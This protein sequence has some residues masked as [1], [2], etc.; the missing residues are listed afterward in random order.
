MESPAAAAWSCTAELARSK[1]AGAPEP[2]LLT[3]SSCRQSKAPVRCA[4]SVASRK[5]TS[6]RAPVRWKTAPSSRGAFLRLEGVGV[7]V[8]VVLGLNVGGAD[9]EAVAV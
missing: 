1:E 3:V 9:A 6:N 7:A 5:V 4:R 8:G 2:R